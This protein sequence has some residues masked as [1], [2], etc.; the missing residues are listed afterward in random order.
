MQYQCRP[1]GAAEWPDPVTVTPGECVFTPPMVEHRTSFPV[2][3]VLVSASKLGR[4]HETHEADLV[5]IK[6]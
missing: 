3:T 4:E 2:D 1:V 6:K 5:R